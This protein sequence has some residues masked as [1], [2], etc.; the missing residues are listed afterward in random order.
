[1]VRL[2]FNVGRR[3]NTPTPSL[4]TVGIDKTYHWSIS[5][6]LIV[7]ISVRFIKLELLDSELHSQLVLHT[8]FIEA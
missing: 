4:Q 2:L 3:S 8:I 6:I 7:Y 1:L 5:F